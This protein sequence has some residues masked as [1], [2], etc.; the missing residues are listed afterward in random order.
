MDELMNKVLYVWFDAP[1]GYISATKAWA[2]EKGQD[3]EKW[4]KDEDSKL[5]HFIGKDNIV[6]HCIIFPAMLK[7]HGDYILPTNVPANQFLN[8]EGRKMSTSKNWT[9]WV[10]DFLNDFPNRQD[11]LRYAMIQN[12]PEN[13]DSDFSWKDFQEKNNNELVANL[14]NFINRVAVL[15]WKYF[16]GKVQTAGNLEDIDKEL[17]NKIKESSQL[18]DKNLESYEFKSGLQEL[19]SL[20]SAGNRYL[21]ELEPWKLMKTDAKRTG[22]ILH[23]CT[24]LIYALT[25][26][27]RAFLPSSSKKIAEM[28]N[29]ELADKWSFDDFNLDG[30][31]IEK[32][33]LLFSKIEDSEIEA[34]IQKLQSTLETKKEENKDFEPLKPAIEYGDF[35]KMD[36]RVGT[37]LSAEKVEKTDKLLQMQVDLGFE[38][39]T[40]VSGI[41]QHFECDKI[42]GQKVLVLA[43]LAPKKLRGIM[44]NGM[45]LL[46]EDDENGLNFVAAPENVTNGAQVM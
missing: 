12:L 46:S 2:E 1:I 36:L 21:A 20:S 24:Q 37:I 44:S 34:Q 31:Q 27:S 11:E 29:F 4:W 39:R 15:T 10:H 25:N 32:S 18:I 8:L 22:E 13:K 3:W 6:F 26:L 42:I 33:R 41:A 35:S 43:N 23:H 40:I 9:V 5:V 17:Y 28:F 45:I 16:D 30:H 7:A 19:M 14:G 38:E